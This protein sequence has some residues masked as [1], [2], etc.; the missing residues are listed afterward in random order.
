MSILHCRSK[1]K[2]VWR[3]EYGEL[4]VA[5]P[6][7][8]LSVL[9]MVAL[10]VLGYLLRKY[11]LLRRYVSDIENHAVDVHDDDDTVDDGNFMAPPNDP[12]PDSSVDEEIEMRV[13]E[14]EHEEAEP[15]DVEPD[16]QG[17]TSFDES[18]SE[19]LNTSVTPLMRTP[20]CSTPKRDEY[21][22]RVTPKTTYPK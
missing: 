20:Q 10:T 6:A 17:T 5:L 3:S 2:I 9:L 8:G 18:L 16:Q 7:G 21:L 14:E 19:S 4:E 22:L 1:T 11:I 13:K 15:S 12:T